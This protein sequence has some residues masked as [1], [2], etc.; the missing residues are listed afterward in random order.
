MKRRFA[1][2]P[3]ILTAAYV[4]VVAGSVSAF[5]A[6]A[7][8]DPRG[9]TPKHYLMLVNTAIAFQMN[10]AKL[11]QF[12][13]S[14]Y[15]AIAIAFLHAYDSS[16]APSVAAMNAQLVQ[17]KRST[18]KDIWPWVYINRMIGKNPKEQ[19]EHSDTPYFQSMR[20][21]DLADKNGAKSDFL[22]IWQNSIEAARDSKMP[23]V[24]LDLEFYNNYAGYDV[25]QL[26]AQTGLKP[27]EVADNLQKLGVRMADIAA[28]QY[29]G[30]ILW[31]AFTGLTHPGYKRY[32]G[33]PY[34]PSPAYIAIGLLDELM[35]RK[36]NMK[37]LAGGETSLAYCHDTLH[38]FDEAVTKRQSDMASM[39]ERY[40]TV[41]L[42]LAGTMT[43][44]SDRPKN[45]VCPN[46][47]AN[48]IEDLEPYIEL[49][50]NSYR[51]NWIWASAGDGNYD[52]F[53][54]ASAPRFD[55]VIRQAEVAAHRQ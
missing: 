29:P 44:W 19:N 37:V 31:L 10:D 39:L 48:S 38:A 43:V 8:I 16:A 47:T 40:A 52:A 21:A 15:D 35:R 50:L 55:T 3:L 45:K 9:V 22:Q 36:T 41:P 20:G 54:T 34:Y 28:E 14:P 4:A 53:A 24:F 42:E 26:A 46:A 6:L 30:G 2:G 51:Y 11:R 49:M 23:G 12:D 32:D 33:V 27:N 7:K 1:V 13:R 18:G 5:G 25:G 17:W